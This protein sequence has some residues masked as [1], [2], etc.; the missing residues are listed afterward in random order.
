MLAGQKLRRIQGD[1]H[2]LGGDF[3]LDATGVLRLAHTSKDPL[4]RP[5]V[6]TLLAVLEQIT[7]AATMPTPTPAPQTRKG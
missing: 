3:V 2:Q 7:H 6:E 5:A 4:D 1:P